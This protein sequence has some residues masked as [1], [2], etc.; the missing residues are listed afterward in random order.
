MIARAASGAFEWLYPIR[1]VAALAGLWTFRR[2]YLGLDW[3]VSMLAPVTGILVFIVWIAADRVTGAAIPM[4]AA[5]AS[6]SAWARDGWIAL[7]ILGAIFTVPLAEE[8]AFRGFL[9]RRFTRSDFESVPFQSAT[10]LALLGSSALFGLMHGGRWLPAAAAGALYALL[11][12]RTG[13]MGDAVVAHAT[14]N[15]LLAAFVLFYEQW[16]LW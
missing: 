14:T 7:R 2:S 3:R 13:R 16:Q 11:I 5:L 6:A 4:P 10:W 12:K 1:F 8:L 15:A 9:L